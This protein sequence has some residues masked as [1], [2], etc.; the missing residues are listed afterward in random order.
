MYMKLT[1]M[2]FMKNTGKVSIDKSFKSGFKNLFRP[3]HAFKFNTKLFGLL[4]VHISF[5]C[6]LKKLFEM[7]RRNVTISKRWQAVAMNS[8]GLS[9]RRI[10][11]NFE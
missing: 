2:I 4:H 6:Y 1:T 7:V 8:A 5:N 10:A 3:N 9:I 11:A